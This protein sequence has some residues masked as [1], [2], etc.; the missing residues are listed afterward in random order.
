MT[1]GSAHPTPRWQRETGRSS[2]GHLGAPRARIL[3]WPAFLP[4]TLLCASTLAEADTFWQIRT[5]LLTIRHRRNRVHAR[6]IQLEVDQRRDENPSETNGSCRSGESIKIATRRP[7]PGLERH[8]ADCPHRGERHEKPDTSR[9]A[10]VL[11]ARSSRT[12]AANGSKV[13]ALD[14]CRYLGCDRGAVEQAEPNRSHQGLRAVAC[15]E[16]FVEAAN[17]GLG[18]RQADE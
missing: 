8:D 15:S 11:G 18:R 14:P 9:R 17:V 3:A 2:R 10:C 4:I 16:L 1:I 13:R 5:G 7:R 12:S 6:G